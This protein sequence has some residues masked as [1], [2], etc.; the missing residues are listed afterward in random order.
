MDIPEGHAISVDDIAFLQG[1]LPQIHDKLQQEIC[2]LNRI[3]F[4]LALKV[5]FLKETADDHKEY[6]EPMLRH[7]QDPLLQVSEIDGALEKAF[8]HIL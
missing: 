3:K 4:Q 8:P 7:K 1:V 2:S 5:V 6:I